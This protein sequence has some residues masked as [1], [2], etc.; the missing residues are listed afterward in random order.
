MKNLLFI[1]LIILLAGCNPEEKNKNSGSMVL[2]GE[3]IYN[4]NCLSCHGP[5]GQGLAKD[6]KVKDENGNYPAPPLNGTAHTWHHSPEQLLYTINKG[7]VEMG[8]QMPAFEKRLTEEEKKAL[9]E[10]M[11]SLWPKEIQEK[12]DDRF[13]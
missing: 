3:K 7:G 4:K 8:G 9:I 2:L 12:Y 13:K 5:K 6:W 10:Y 11:Y 1:P